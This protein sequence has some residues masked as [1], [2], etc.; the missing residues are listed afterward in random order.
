MPRALSLAVVLALASTGCAMAHERVGSDDAAADGESSGCGL[1]DPPY[2]LG[3]CQSDSFVLGCVRWSARRVPR[4]LG[5]GYEYCDGLGVCARTNARI[6][7]RGGGYQC[8]RG[9]RCDDAG[10]CFCG[11]NPECGPGEVCVDLPD[12]GV[13]CV[14]GVGAP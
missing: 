13:G 1:D 8:V 7:C 11:E 2:V 6:A 14:C 12:G 10:T 5:A 4:G 9:D 3:N